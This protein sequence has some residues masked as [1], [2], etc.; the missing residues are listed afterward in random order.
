MGPFDSPKKPGMNM[1]WGSAVFDQPT[2]DCALGTFSL[3]RHSP[4]VYDMNG[5]YQSVCSRYPLRFVVTIRS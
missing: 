4:Q 3:Q 2:I 1:D 5:S